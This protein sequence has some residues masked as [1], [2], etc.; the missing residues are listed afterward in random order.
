VG[1]RYPGGTRRVGTEGGHGAPG[2]E[3]C[4]ASEVAGQ[5]QGE[6]LAGASFPSFLAEL[7]LACFP[8]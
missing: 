6:T 8:A 5:W 4:E 1:T 3:A 2:S 7:V